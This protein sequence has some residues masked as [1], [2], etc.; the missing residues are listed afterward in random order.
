MARRCTGVGTHPAGR[1]AATRHAGSSRG[2][3]RS[4]QPRAPLTAAAAILWNGGDA[5]VLRDASPM[6]APKGQVRFPVL[7]ITRD[8]CVVLYENEQELTTVFGRKG[9]T[10]QPI[11]GYI[12]MKIIDQEGNLF[13]VREATK[14]RDL[15][16]LYPS[17]SLSRFL[18]RTRRMEA[19]LSLSAVGSISFEETK[20]LIRDLLPSICRSLTSAGHDT[21]SLAASIGQSKTIQELFSLVGPR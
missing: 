2:A 1:G 11:P 6:I 13:E 19:S 12:G 4:V 8:A 5:S 21:D 3:G 14:G 7:S 15:G 18:F 17:R 10:G 9:S 20:R 16:S